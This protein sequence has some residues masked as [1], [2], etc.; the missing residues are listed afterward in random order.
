[1]ENYS[2]LFESSTKSIAELLRGMGIDLLADFIN[3]TIVISK[4][5]SLWSQITLHVVNSINTENKIPVL[6]SPWVYGWITTDNAWYCSSCSSY[7]RHS[8]AQIVHGLEFNEDTRRCLYEQVKLSTKMTWEKDFS[9]KRMS[10]PSCRLVNFLS[11]ANPMHQ[12][13]YYSN[14]PALVGALN[15]STNDQW[16]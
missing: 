14:Q 8:H 15:S 11:R 12:Q 9:Q 1:M 5:I 16:I 2:K 7:T 4:L 6:T 3:A 13:C 10:M